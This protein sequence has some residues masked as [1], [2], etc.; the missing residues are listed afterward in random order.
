MTGNEFLQ[1]LVRI[2]AAL[3]MSP[4]KRETNSVATAVDKLCRK[5]R[6]R[7]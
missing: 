7:C 1:A 3:Y 2:A 5:L 4:E 6:A